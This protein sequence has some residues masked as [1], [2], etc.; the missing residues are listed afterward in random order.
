MTGTEYPFLCFP[1]FLIAE[2]EQS[3]SSVQSEGRGEYAAADEVCINEWMSD[4]IFCANG[5]ILR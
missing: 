2:G 5:C 3:C 4:S 1:L